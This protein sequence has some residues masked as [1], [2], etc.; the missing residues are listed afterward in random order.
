[1]TIECARQSKHWRELYSVEA[2]QDHE[3]RGLLFVH[4]HDAQYKGDFELTIAKTDLST[5]D[6]APHVYVHYLGPKDIDR[7]YSIANDLIRLSYEKTLPSE[8]TFYYPDLVMWRRQGDVWEQP[9]TIEALTAPYFIIKYPAQEKSPSGY[10]IYYNRQGASVE[11]FEYFLDSLSRYQMLEPDE[12]IRIRI[13]HK[14][15]HESYKSN[16]ITATS[17]YAKAWGFDPIRTQ[18]LDNIDIR[19]ITSVTTT[20]TAGNIGWRD[21]R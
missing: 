20:Y 15:P 13:V 12:F 17:K 9:A 11:E 10:I 3:V 8:Y 21:G 18:I 14:N 7:L 1:M 16:F 4:N 6:I 19:P 2:G 5:I